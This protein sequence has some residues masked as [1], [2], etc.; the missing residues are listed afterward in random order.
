MKLIR[1]VLMFAVV[2]FAISGIM[3]YLGDGV[4]QATW[5]AKFG[6]IGVMAIFIFIFLIIIYSIAKAVAKGAAAARRKSFPQNNQDKL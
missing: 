4:I 1:L 6:E 5:G 2:S 3:F